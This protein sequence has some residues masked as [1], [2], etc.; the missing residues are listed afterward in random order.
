MVWLVVPGETI[1]WAG[2]P[3]ETRAVSLQPGQNKTG[4]PVIE[5]SHPLVTGCGCSPGCARCTA[6]QTPV[7]ARRV[8]IKLNTEQIIFISFE[9]T[10]SYTYIDYIAIIN[11][12]H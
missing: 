12:S 1:D 11:R 7:S 9:L 4:E 8:F 10:K 3:D 2:P 5:D 6:R